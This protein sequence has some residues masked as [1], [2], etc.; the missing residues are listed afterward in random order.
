MA[1]YDPEMDTITIKDL[2]SLQ[3]ERLR[4]V[5]ERCY[6][7]GPLPLRVPGGPYRKCVPFRRL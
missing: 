7:K 6:E 5:V 3:N 2:Q 1:Y 4:K